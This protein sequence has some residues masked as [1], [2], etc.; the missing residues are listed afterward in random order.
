MRYT[1]KQSEDT[2]TKLVAACGRAFRRQGLTGIGVDGLAK[3]AGVTSGAFYRHFD[4][5]NAAFE[6]VAVDALDGLVRSVDSLRRAYPLDWEA[7]FID[8]YLGERLKCELEESCP[9]QALTPDVVRT[10][11]DT[12]RRYEKS[13]K[14]LVDC[15]AEGLSRVPEAERRARATALLSLLSGG[16]TI[17]RSLASDALRDTMVVGLKSAAQLLIGR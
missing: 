4:S 1:R 15:V 16:V 5:K 3:E 17:A 7:R 11:I 14:R 9:L 10:E 12:R 8:F 6:E 2:R 13:L